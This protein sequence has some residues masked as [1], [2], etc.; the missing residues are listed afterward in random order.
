MRSADDSGQEHGIAVSVNDRNIVVILI[1]AL[2]H[3]HNLQL[4]HLYI[5]HRYWR[6]HANQLL[7]ITRSEFGLLVPFFSSLS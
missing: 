3:C 5:V 4:L 2:V 1:N 6:H 7:A